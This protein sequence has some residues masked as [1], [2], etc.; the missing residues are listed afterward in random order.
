MS[1]S[2]LLLSLFEYKAW[3]DAELGVDVGKLDVSSHPAERHGA[4]RLLNHIHVVD[5]IFA[6]H[7][8]GSAHGYT[9]TNTAET[10]TLAELCAA[11]A[12]VDRWYVDYLNGL[13]TERLSE[14]LAFTFT[15]GAP[16]LM[17]R[18]EMLAHVLT[19][20]AHHRGAVGRIL[21]QC[22]LTP[23]R[24]LF[25]VHLHAAEPERRARR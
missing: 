25:T 20:G 24:D 22:S 23:P 11:V 3:A 15:D 21:A 19:H 18:E 14:R 9:A 7:L 13:A 17:S 6:A 5:R 12:A 16:G 4:I 1:A 8:A 10:P 2:T